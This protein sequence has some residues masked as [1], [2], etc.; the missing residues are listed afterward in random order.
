MLGND[1]KVLKTL[2]LSEISLASIHALE[3]VRF[4]YGQA[5]LQFPLTINGSYSIIYFYK[6]IILSINI[7]KC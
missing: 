1:R 5:A 4:G 7:F 3:P 6:N 2:E